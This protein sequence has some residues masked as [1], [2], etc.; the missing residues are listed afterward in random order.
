MRI[1]LP[2]LFAFAFLPARAA[3]EPPTEWIDAATG[4]R[5]IRLSREPGSASLYFNQNAYTTEGDK[6]II[7]TPNGISTIDLKTHE[8]KS[9]VEGR[10]RVIVAGRKSRQVYYSKDGTIYATHLDTRE[11][12][13]IAKLPPRGFVATL[14]ADETLL[15]GARTDGEGQAY[16]DPNRPAL[17]ATAARPSPTPIIGADGKPLT[18]AEAKEV[19][20]N[21]RLEQHTPMS[22][23]T[24]DVKSGEIKTIHSGTD[25]F[26]HLQ[27]SPGDP[28]LLMF[29]H[30]GPWHKVDRIWTIRTDGT[31]LTKIHTRTMNMEIAG[32]EFFS[33]D[34]KTIW[35]DLQT[36][37]GEDFWL[38]GYELATGRR[39]WYHL[40]R[41]EWSVHFNVAPDGTLFA[42]DGGDNEMVAHA[43]DG[44]WIY[45]FR[46]QK[47][48]DVAGIKAPNS[49]SLIRPGFFKSERLVDMS[50]HEYRLEPNVSFTP[51]MKWIVF[52]S[53]MFGPTQVFAVEIEK[54]ST[55]QHAPEKNLP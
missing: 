11:T 38:A 14:N 18:F 8:I 6:L 55:H 33:A 10:V 17:D 35:Y 15:A 9:V 29:C 28:S 46:P 54:A 23:F 31:A 45:L 1:F 36:P 25:W 40:Q 39:T 5:V 12:R 2:L 48:P 34:G 53:N 21:N 19:R 37:R 16:D 30:E 7:T 52:R 49:E 27:F 24:V 50:K 47:I 4:H 22:I 41:D 51:D 42:G 32:H 44:K 26:G 43:K 3:D 20:M 13:E